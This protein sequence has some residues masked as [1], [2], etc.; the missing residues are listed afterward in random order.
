ML[1]LYT[2]VGADGEPA[3]A[4]GLVVLHVH[5]GKRDQPGVPVKGVLPGLDVG[6]G[7]RQQK[8]EVFDL[9]ERLVREARLLLGLLVLRHLGEERGEGTK[10]SWESRNKKCE[11]EKWR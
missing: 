11:K 7:A 3:H 8:V 1:V 2:V 9:V 5:V 6:I 10:D 4:L